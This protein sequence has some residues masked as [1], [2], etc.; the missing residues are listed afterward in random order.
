[1]AK[2]PKISNVKEMYDIDA[3][4]MT[5]TGCLYWR[6][7]RFG[8]RYLSKKDLI[9][10]LNLTV[11]MNIPFFTIV[12]FGTKSY[13]KIQE[14]ISQGENDYSKKLQMQLY[15]ALVAQTLIPM[16]FL[17][18]PVGFLFYCPLIG[19]DI[20]CSSL[21]ITFFYSFYPA[22]DPLPNLLFIDEYRNAFFNF[23]RRAINGNQVTSV[24]SYDLNMA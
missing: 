4:K 18:I 6:I 10:A 24:V 12:Y 22:V 2:M 19:I 11:I 8:N 20:S 21:L 17:F 5:Y 1:M 13:R 14:L 16:V 3:D 15:K 7:D 9:G 23:F